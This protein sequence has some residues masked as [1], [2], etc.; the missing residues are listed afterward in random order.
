MVE[1]LLGPAG[2]WGREGVALGL[3]VAIKAAAAVAL[4]IGAHLALGRRRALVQS[5][6]WNACLVGLLVL[7]AA[8]AAFPAWRIACLPAGPKPAPVEVGPMAIEPVV[9][10]VDEAPV[11]GAAVEPAPKTA[12]NVD[13]ATVVVLV[14]GI[15]AALLLLRL[16]VSWRAAKGLSRT[17]ET[18][19]TG[20]WVEALGRWRARL[21]LTS[22]VRLARSARLGVPVVVGWRRPTILLPEGLGDAT[23]KAVVDA[24]LLH[25]LAHVR[26][27]DYPWNVLLRLLQAIY[28][29]HPMV[30][31]AGR[32][33]H[34]V[35]EQAC[36]DL[37][38]GWLE[39]SGSYRD[40]LLD[41]ASGLARRPKGALGMALALGMARSSR[42]GKRLERIEGSAGASRCLLRGPARLAVAMLVVATVV[43]LGTVRLA[44]TAAA[45]PQEPKATPKGEDEP[46]DRGEASKARYGLKVDRAKAAELGLSA[47]EVIKAATQALRA[48]DRT[49]RSSLWID[50][51]DK[52][53]YFVGRNATV[54][55]VSLIDAVLDTKV[56]AEKPVP[57]RNLVI[58]IRTTARQV[59]TARVG[60]RTTG[61]TTV[62]PCTL[63]PYEWANL[64]ARVTGYLASVKVDIGDSV[65]KGDVLATIEAPDLRV[66]LDRAAAKLQQA[67]AR[68]SQ[69]AAAVRSS[70]AAVQGRK[71]KLKQAEADVKKGQ[72]HV[73]KWDTEVKRLEKAVERQVV[74]QQ[75]LHESKLQREAAVADLDA[76]RAA[77]ESARANLVEAE[78]DIEASKAGLLVAET[79]VKV[80]EADLAKARLLVDAT[81]I[82]SPYDGLVTNR[83]ANIGDLVRAEAGANAPPI[84]RVVRTDVMRAVVQVP[85]ADAPFIRRGQAATVR[86][87]SLRED[88]RGQVARFAEA[89]D[90]ATRTMRTEI[91]LKN[92]DR[93]LRAGMFGIATIVLDEN[94]KPGLVIPT[95]AVITTNADGH[96]TCFRLVNGRAV[97]TTFRYADT[98]D[99]PYEVLEGLDE[100]DIVILRPI[101][102]GAELR[103][104]EPVTTK[105]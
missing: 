38:V 1:E 83:N 23:P 101:G 6:V 47:D 48:D 60:R 71:A 95:A 28:W 17:G 9:S 98:D 67:R 32:L 62:Q 58:V 18:V 55:G 88:F 53:L 45:A 99:G 5:A 81:M 44:R 77:A 30:W 97:S 40:A 50:P 43:V 70:Q 35:R 29:P 26:R 7:P 63:Q 54:D 65:K 78:A 92:P 10:A 25:E 57:L 33:I 105:D 15:G 94:P 84:F 85:D 93:R 80:A 68:L 79:E 56:A 72:S 19:E 41:V 76:A 12:R 52:T 100:G 91:D 2:S 86:F 27:G 31:L 24:V 3:D 73:D 59:A 13:G 66:D 42:L 89:E 4:A 64:S 22:N 69:A 8:A 49:E 104:G 14:Y 75:V 46:K 11:V 39:G 103:D 37:C 51:T 34:S 82:R 74:A 16:V 90:V 102:R 20:P 21:G 96:A 61:R 36:D 87:K